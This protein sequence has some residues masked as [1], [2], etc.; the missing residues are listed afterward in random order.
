MKE[1]PNVDHHPD[2]RIADLRIPWL[3][4]GR[5]QSRPEVHLRHRRDVESGSDAPGRQIG[6]IDPLR[7]RGGRRG[8]PRQR[9]E[10]SNAGSAWR[11]RCDR[12]AATLRIDRD[13][14]RWRLQVQPPNPAYA[15]QS[16]N[17]GAPGPIR[18]GGAADGGGCGST[19]LDDCVSPVARWSQ[20]LHPGYGSDIARPAC[21]IVS[22]ITIIY[23]PKPAEKP[24]VARP[25]D[26]EINPVNR[27]GVVVFS[28][29]G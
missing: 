29:G 28:T 20:R 8:E 24:P 21:P 12:A 2:R 11:G 4:R 6:C 18:S 3:V 7:C 27:S 10:I 13:H 23:S 26:D 22:A 19:C 14:Y 15:Q 25:N 5:T 1:R 9:D 17:R 16:R